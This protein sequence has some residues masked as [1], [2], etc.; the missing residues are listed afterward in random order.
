MVFVVTVFLVH[1]GLA[2]R[3]KSAWI[4]HL[5]RGKPS[6]L[7]RDGQVIDKALAREGIS[8]EELLAGLRKLGYDAP[9]AVK[10]AV[11]EE[12][13]HISA[14]GA[15]DAIRPRRSRRSSHRS[16]AASSGGRVLRK[17]CSIA[18]CIRP[19]RIDM[20]APRRCRPTSAYQHHGCPTARRRWS[21]GR[22]VADS[23]I[24]VTVRGRIDR[25]DALLQR[26]VRKQQAMGFNRCLNQPVGIRRVHSGVGI[27]VH[28]DHGIMRSYGTRRRELQ[29]A[30]LHQ[31]RR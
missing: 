28:H 15:A 5:V 9:E 8:R 24:G 18:G 6:V 7:V 2:A 11:L 30:G 26:P 12:T 16:V 27:T 22:F 14:V 1:R 17:N 13:G 4:R 3:A 23:L 19:A 21:V 29:I 20:R 10:L 31:C 25:I